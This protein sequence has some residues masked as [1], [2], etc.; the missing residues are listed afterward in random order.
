MI[1]TVTVNPCL[2]V[3]RFL[4]AKS[5]APSLSDGTYRPE[6]PNED[7]KLRPGGKGI[8]VSRAL[9]CLQNETK[10]LGFIGDQT[11][12][13]L[14]GL[15]AAEG[16]DHEFIDSGVETRT[17]I[18]LVL[19]D[20]REHSKVLGE[21]RINSQGKEIPPNKYQ[22][23]YGQANRIGDAKAVAISGSLSFNMQPTFYNS[24]IRT[25]KTKNPGCIVL[26]DGPAAPTAEAMVLPQHRP[27]FIK[28][29]IK[30]FSDLVTQLD[31]QRHSGVASF[32]L[33]GDQLPS[34]ASDEQYLEYAF[35][36]TR[37]ASGPPKD[38]EVDKG[39]FRSNWGVL[40]QCVLHIK[41]EFGVTT[42]LSLGPAGCI[43]ADDD[44]RILHAYIPQ[45]IKIGTR[46]GAGDCLAAG[47]LSKHVNDPSSNPLE[48]AL[49]AGIAAATAR[50]VVEEYGANKKYLDRKVYERYLG[51]VKLDTY[52]PESALV[53]QFAG[54]APWCR[55]S[56]G[57]S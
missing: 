20:A 51:Q 44:G 32:P 21:I 18:I 42:L 34:G 26:L 3:L 38:F 29:N 33:R 52:S 11:G 27:D 40:L 25:F 28:P 48:N 54:T 56:H 23:L 55:F 46:V 39:K 1:Y 36:G 24:L 41:Q 5:Q 37:L 4:S 6:N 16:I 57:R 30:E 43:S 31:L 10:A 50:I 53:P 15:L 2:D 9:V 35:T 8:D 12:E 49:K 13:I 14:K 22:L 45:Q 19:R 17:N 47:F 7:E